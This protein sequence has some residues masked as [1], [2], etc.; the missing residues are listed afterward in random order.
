MKDDLIRD[1]I[2]LGIFDAELSKQM[3]VIPDLTLK[4]A[5]DTVPSEQVES[6][7]EVR[8]DANLPTVEQIH[9]KRTYRLRQPS[10]S[11]YSKPSFDDR[12]GSL[13]A[14]RPLLWQGKPCTIRL[15]SKKRPLFQV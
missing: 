7:Q 14:V 8:R 6:Q 11:S 10:T 12:K 3:Q 4:K 1:H 9:G 15:A 13:N 2:V 5:I